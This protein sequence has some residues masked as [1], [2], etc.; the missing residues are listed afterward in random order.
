MSEPDA[1]Q[2][3]ARRFG[4][5]GPIVRHF[6]HFSRPLKALLVCDAL[7]T[8]GIALWLF[9]VVTT[10]LPAHDPAH[11]TLWTAFALGFLA[12]AAVTL[13]FVVRGPHPA[14]LPAAVV[15]LSLAAIAFGG[16]AVTSM[17]AAADAGRHF[18]GYLLLM[19]VALAGHGLCAL[20]YTTL[21]ALISHR[22]HAA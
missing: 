9:A 3:A 20:A 10:V 6:D 11:V 16:Y 14:L 15:V 8:A 22:V 12:Y 18:E 7:A 5:P 19:G 21:T 1:E 2:A 17:L 13:A 4:A